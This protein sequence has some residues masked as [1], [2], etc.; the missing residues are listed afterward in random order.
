MS[1]QK[2]FNNVTCPVCG[3]YYAGH[4]TG[5]SD[6]CTCA[7]DYKASHRNDFNSD[8][9]YIHNQNERTPLTDAQPDPSHLGGA[10]VS[11][12]FARELERKLTEAN[13]MLVQSQIDLLGRKPATTEGTPRTDER[14]RTAQDGGYGG[15]F[16]MTEHA[17]QLERELA[18]ANDAADKGEAGRKMG[19]AL[20]G[21]QEENRTLKD[22]KIIAMRTALE[23]GYLCHEKGFNLEMTHFKFN[24]TLK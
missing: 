5:A 15:M 1:D 6:I 14:Y 17:R 16:Q 11:K 7:E 2:A 4:A 10:C 3:M 19:T 9:E 8:G 24:E 23:F 21:C 18:M 12:E 13:S 20:E 22:S